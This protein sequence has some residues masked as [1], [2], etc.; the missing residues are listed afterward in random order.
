VPVERWWVR[1]EPGGPRGTKPADDASFWRMTRPLVSWQGAGNSRRQSTTWTSR[2][3]GRNRGRGMRP[4]ET[5]DRAGLV[6]RVPMRRLRLQASIHAG[7]A[8]LRTMGRSW[9][10]RRRARATSLCR[11]SESLRREWP[12]RDT[13]PIQKLK[14]KK[15][16]VS[17]SRA[18]A[19]GGVGNAEVLLRRLSGRR[20][21]TR[22]T[23]VE[24][25][26]SGVEHTVTRAPRPAVH[27]LFQVCFV[28]PECRA[29]E[30]ARGRSP[31]VD[32]PGSSGPR[33]C[34]E[35]RRQRGRHS[36][37]V[38]STRKYVVALEHLPHVPGAVSQNEPRPGA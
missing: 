22:W 14:M 2:P 37:V 5:S 16:V 27:R 31:H 21:G 28:T 6:D 35:K 15:L 19:V 13:P 33:P 36:F 4:A 23:T 17:S 18:S 9:P 1:A 29:R 11:C 38:M 20:G 7:R 26:R 32:F 3:D 10:R 24:G 34:E 30:L 12:Q 25:A 8:R